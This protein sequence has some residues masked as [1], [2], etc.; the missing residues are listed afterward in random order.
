MGMVEIRAVVGEL[1]GRDTFLIRGIGGVDRHAGFGRDS[2]RAGIQAEQRVEAVVR[3]HD[4]YEVLDGSRGRDPDR[5]ILIRRSLLRG[6]DNG[7]MEEHEHD[8]QDR[9]RMGVRRM[10][11]RAEMSHGR[12]S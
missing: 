2:I 8:E 11:Q 1:E 4:R 10:R 7:P 3:L 9:Q 5:L 6:L 12:T